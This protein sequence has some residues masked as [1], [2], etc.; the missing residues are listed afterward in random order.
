[1]WMDV[2]IDPTRRRQTTSM[3]FEQV[4]E[5][6][7]SGRLVPG[8][9]LP[10]SRDLAADLGVARSTVTTVYSRLVAEGVLD[11][12][13]GDGTFVADH[14]AG[15]RPGR[16]DRGELDRIDLTR[17]PPPS[18]P[19][20]RSETGF[21]LPGVGIDWPG[22]G[23]H[24][25]GVGIHWPRVGIHWEVDLR[26]G[27]PDPALFPLV[28][29][30]RAVNDAVEIAPPG[31][32]DP[33]GF[34]RLRTAI[35]TWVS[36]SRGLDASPDQVLITAGAQQAFDLCART[37]IARNDIVAFEDPGYEPARRAF[38]HHGARIQPVPIDREG[39]AV[40]WIDR[41][42]RLVFVTPSHQLPTGV[43][44][45][46]GRRRDL[47]ELADARGMAVIEDD[48]DTE[49]RFVDRPLEPLR[50][51]DPNGRVVYL[52]TFSK[53]LTPSLRIGFVVAST[54]VIADLTA[55]RA[56]SDV[57]PPHLTQA[58]LA[59]L[60]V[61]GDLDRHLRRTR[62]V[63]RERHAFVESRVDELQSDGLVPTTWHSNAGLHTMIELAPSTDAEAI[64]DRLAAHG[65]LLETTRANW[66]GAGRPGLLV[67]YGLADIA[68]LDRA[69]TA[70]RSVLQT[71]A[72]PSR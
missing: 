24:W 72:A 60:I 3:L 16:T 14:S 70:L 7:A 13:V 34:P 9:R 41:S 2:F 12:R 31:Y 8:E 64:A 37:L 39:I 49:Y 46:A 22:V 19:A 15:M 23:I 53:T 59:T 68:Q 11:A 18:A 56:V 32:G 25:P 20:S 35:A 43:T 17:R 67:G 66:C 29:W 52:G 47:L 45:S 26:T 38:I 21:D 54:A 44:L 40:E 5:A 10:T 57:Q 55:T 62:A 27:R 51:R 1:M 42:A 58:A 69:F 30:R 48:Y 50:R 28:A 6:I 61:R 65:V 36:R 71:R 4:R 33:A 63:Y